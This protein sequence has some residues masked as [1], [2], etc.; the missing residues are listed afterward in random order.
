MDVALE[1]SEAA[2]LDRVIRPEAAGWP[3]SAAE[4]ILCISFAKKDRE[5]MS[6]LLE[7]AKTGNLP[8]AEAAE[9]EHYRHVGRLLELLKSRARHSL[10][11]RAAA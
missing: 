11:N 4:A 5:L 3:R 9:A 8:A 2:I 1:S 7:K 10:R 6:L